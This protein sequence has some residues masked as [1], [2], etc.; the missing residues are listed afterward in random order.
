MNGEKRIRIRQVNETRKTIVEALLQLLEKNKLSEL[1][2][3]QVTR[4][5]GYARRTF[6]RHFDSLDDV[7]T[8]EIDRNTKTMFETISAIEQLKFETMVEVFF[9]FGRPIKTYYQS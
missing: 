9:I 8:Y 6:Y 4:R 2:I 5:A 3:E 7:L 1:T